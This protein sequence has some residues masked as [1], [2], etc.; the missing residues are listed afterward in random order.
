MMVV[1]LRCRD[2]PVPAVPSIRR[3][4][5]DCDQMVWVSQRTVRTAL[6]AGPLLLPLCVRCA[7]SRTAS[8]GV[9]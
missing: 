6:R 1:A 5:L 4:C 9:R 7:A 2:L 3:S 8:A